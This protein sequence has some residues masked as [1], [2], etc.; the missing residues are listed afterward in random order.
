[1]RIRMGKIKLVYLDNN[2]TKVLWGEIISEDDFFISFKTEDEKFFRIGK[3]H[4]ITIKEIKS[5]SPFGQEKPQ[6]MTTAGN[7]NSACPHKQKKALPYLNLSEGKSKN[8][9]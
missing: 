2:K 6:S 3:S 4:I 5:H 1:M 8:E 9:L 7:T